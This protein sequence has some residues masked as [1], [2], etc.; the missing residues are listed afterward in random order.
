[1]K[2]NMRKTLSIALLLTGLMV[3]TATFA[4]SPLEPTVAAAIDGVAASGLPTEPLVQKAREGA[5]KRVPAAVVVAAVQELGR[6][7]QRAADTLGPR[8]QGPD[9]AAVLSA[10]AAALAAGVSPGSLERLAAQPVE[11]RAAALRALGD[12]VSMGLPEDA[13]V[14]L[15]ERTCAAQGGAVG[16]NELSSTVAGLLGQGMSPSQVAERLSGQAS[17]GAPGSPPAYGAGGKNDKDPN[18]KGLDKAPGQNK[19]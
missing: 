13:S 4:S 7:M 8:A 10:G 11:A 16:V 15:V 14:R 19:K 2:S 3:P 6:Q 12:L 9:R 1:M 18:G 17:G 5:A